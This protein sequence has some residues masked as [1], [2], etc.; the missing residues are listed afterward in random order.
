M[1]HI[2]SI[3]GEIGLNLSSV[4]DFSLYIRNGCIANMMSKCL[5]FDTEP[6]TRT[7]RYNVLYHWATQLLPRGT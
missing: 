2:G 6:W 5:N 4:V 3:R 1:M 7:D